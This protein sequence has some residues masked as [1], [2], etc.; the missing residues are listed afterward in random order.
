MIFL[1]NIQKSAILDSVNPIFFLKNTQK[2]AILDRVNSM[3]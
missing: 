3:I 1:K 2:V